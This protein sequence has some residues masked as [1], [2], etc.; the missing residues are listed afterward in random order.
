M[1][2]NIYIVK[3]N[4]NLYDIAKNNNTTIGILKTLNN[5]DNNILQVGQIL[6]LPSTIEEAMP[7]DYLIYTIQKGDNLFNIAKNYNW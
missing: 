7:S 4:D 3:P 6:K 2:N 5:L 1:Q